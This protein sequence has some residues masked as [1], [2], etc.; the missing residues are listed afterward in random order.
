MTRL[1]R[2]L[3]YAILDKLDRP[4]RPRRRG[5]RGPL[6]SQSY[7]AFIRSLPC[8]CGCRRGPS[9]AAH[10]G[11]HGIGQKSS[12]L[13]CIPLFHEC[14]DLMHR[15]GQEEFER[16]TGICIEYIVEALNT[17]YWSAR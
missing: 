6:R 3:R 17:E 2:F 14:H 10:T 13:T 4:R 5:R 8:C 11:P 16:R 1:V 15:L 9:D 7:L 12:D